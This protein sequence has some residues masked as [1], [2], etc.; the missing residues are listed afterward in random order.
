MH[1]QR[2]KFSTFFQIRKKKN[3]FYSNLKQRKKSNLFLCNYINDKSILIL[4]NIER[5]LFLLL[6][7]E[8]PAK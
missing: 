7:N 6:D 5:I 8:H 1:T 2:L 3:K 4:Q